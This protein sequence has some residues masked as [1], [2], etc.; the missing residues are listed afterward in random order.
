MGCRSAILLFVLAVVLKA[1]GL[2]WTK[3]NE[4]TPCTFGI[5]SAATIAQFDIVVVG[6]TLH[7]LHILLIL[8]PVATKEDTIQTLAKK[9]SGKTVMATVVFETANSVKHTEVRDGV[10]IKTDDNGGRYCEINAAAPDTGAVSVLG[11]EAS[12]IDAKGDVVSRHVF[13]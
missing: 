5:C 2:S 7:Q 13:R 12:E 1:E 4:E 11:I 10:P 9:V 8:H 3:P 6:V